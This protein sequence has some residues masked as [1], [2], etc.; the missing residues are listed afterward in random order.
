MYDKTVEEFRLGDDLTVAEITKFAN[1]DRDYSNKP[2]DLSR[3]ENLLLKYCYAIKNASCYILKEQGALNN[4]DKV[5]AYYDMLIYTINNTVKQSIQHKS[6]C[7]GKGLD[8]VAQRNISTFDCE[9]FNLFADQLGLYKYDVI[10]FALLQAG[11]EAEAF[12]NKRL[13]DRCPNAIVL[14]PCEHVS[15]KKLADSILAKLE[16]ESESE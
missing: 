15:V 10:Q 7:A 2:I 12:E 5:Q 8:Y 11:F 13:F 16:D 14:V 4:K 1:L 6:V 3:N 9:G